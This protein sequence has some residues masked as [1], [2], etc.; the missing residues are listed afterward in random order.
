ME[1]AALRLQELSQHQLALLGQ[2]AGNGKS[3]VSP[4]FEQNTIVDWQKIPRVELA[5]NARVRDDILLVL[6]LVHERLCNQIRDTIET[7][8]D[9]RTGTARRTVGL[10]RRGVQLG[11]RRFEIR[12]RTASYRGEQRGNEI[13]NEV[14][15]RTSQKYISR[16]CLQP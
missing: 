8:S 9:T 13:S 16:R 10:D 6:Q 12:N 11:H 5:I 7:A 2:G 1:Q 14:Q 4:S 15:R 3:E